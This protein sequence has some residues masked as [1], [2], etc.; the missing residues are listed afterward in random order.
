MLRKNFFSAEEIERIVADFRNAGLS[1]EEVA[2]MSFAQKVVINAHAIEPEDIET[3]R[4][5]N[6]A[7]E[8]IFDIILAAS[9]RS[10]FAQALDASGVQPDGAYLDT[11]GDLI[12]VLSVGRPYDPKSG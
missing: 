8:E 4:K 9:A 6:L 5:F 12:D 3:L 11:V 2:I 1:D 7:D 10:F